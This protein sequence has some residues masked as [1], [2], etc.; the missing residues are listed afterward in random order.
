MLGI[1]ANEFD[2][3][4]DAVILA[5][6]E[7][8][9]RDVLRVDLESV[10][11]RFTVA[12]WSGSVDPIAFTFRGDGAMLRDHS[13][14]RTIWW[15]RSTSQLK[16]DYLYAPAADQL[17]QVEA[18]WAA[19][20]LIESLPVS[21]FPL[22]HPIQMRAGE[23]KM[24]QLHWARSANL[25]TP[26]WIFS[27]S[28][29]ELLSFIGR[30]D[31]VVVKPLHTSIVIDS[32]Q[33]DVS[34]MARSI[35]AKQLHTKLHETPATCVFVQECIKKVCDIRVNVF[36]NS[37]VACRIDPIPHNEEVDW[38]PYTEHCKHSIIEIPKDIESSCRK[39]LNLMNLKWGAFD[40]GVTEDG[41][42]IFFEC[43]PNGQWLWIELMTKEPLAEKVASELLLHHSI[44]M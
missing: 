42:W 30:Y 24:S 25:T 34:L 2:I 13:E 44:G 22:G 3:H 6:R 12:A 41:Q 10:S 1:V 18:Y 11:E 29:E 37:S 9:F 38:R 28:R 39:F 5:L 26:A 33:N 32:N 17:D 7:R 14:L 15:R 36:P 43:N 8:G 40:F 20:W 31:R 16:V 23:N 19:R 4:T 35:T 27:N 21:K